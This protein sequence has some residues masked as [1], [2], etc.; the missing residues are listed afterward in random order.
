M[1][2]GKKAKIEKHVE[3]ANN[4]MRAKVG[5]NA[6]SARIANEVKSAKMPRLQK[7]ERT[8]N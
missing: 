7:R 6:K 5:K 1:Q 3:S 4:A 8:Q 2:K